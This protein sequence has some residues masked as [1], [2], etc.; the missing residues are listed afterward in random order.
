M[1]FSKPLSTQFADKDGSEI[2]D[3]GTLTIAIESPNTS[4]SISLTTNDL[5]I[6]D[7]EIS[8]DGTIVYRGD[9]TSAV[10]IGSVDA[11][12][13]GSSGKLVINLADPNGFKNG[14]FDFVDLNGWTISEEWV[15][16]DGISD[17]YG[18]PTPLDSSRPDNA[19]FTADTQSNSGT[20]SGS[21]NTTPDTDQSGNYSSNGGNIVTLQSSGYSNSYGIVHGPSLVSDSTFITNDSSVSFEWRAAPGEDAYDVYAYLLNLDDSSHIELL[22][23][24]G[25]SGS[26]QTSWANETVDVPIGGNYAFVFLAGS[27]DFSG[28]QALG[29]TL[30]V[31]GIS[32][33][34]GTPANPSLSLE[35]LEDITNLLI[36]KN[37]ETLLSEDRELTITA[38]ESTPNGGSVLNE[39]I[40]FYAKV[41]PEGADNT[42][43]IDEDIPHTF[44][45]SDFGFTD[46]DDDA[47]S[48]VILTSLPSAGTLELNG[49]A[50][51]EEQ[52][53]TAN[54]ISS[55]VFSPAANA[56]GDSYASFDFQVKDDSGVDVDTDESPNTIT[57]DVTPVDDPAVI[58]GDLS[59][60]LEDNNGTFKLEGSIS[61]S[62][63]D[64]DDSP[65]FSDIKKKDSDRGRPSAA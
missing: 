47:L 16:L 40:T 62:D 63:V 14:N 41:A 4:D 52:S 31:D 59:G 45:A 36:Y 50:V 7:G 18:I 26:A 28:G 49:H 46:A 10:A 12:D 9:G 6:V 24:T 27:F 39:E 21:I 5:S 32:I 11:N 15:R 44:Q 53:I 55:L 33:D 48:A 61:I 57:F 34:Q 13:D 64:I 17:I 65:V 58:S 35:N 43:V 37:T 2:F 3:N 42:I 23:A 29:A 25:D 1:S 54:W 30:E 38:T 51:T 19:P 8:S 22:N 60:K 56:N 20:F